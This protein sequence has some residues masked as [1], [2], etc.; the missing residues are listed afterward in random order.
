MLRSYKPT[1]VTVQVDGQPP[2]AGELAV[3]SNTRNYGGLFTLAERARVD[4]GH[5]DICVLSRASLPDLLRTAAG[6][7][8][9]G[10]SGQAGVTYMTGREV[11]IDAEESVAVQLD[12]D[13]F[14]RSPVRIGL[15]PAHVPFI[16]PRA[17]T[18]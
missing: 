14:G 8:T 9:G 17:G 18:S 11:A 1:R 2:V 4:S 7:L 13:Y 5:L 16:C 10:I 6:G 12:G 3:V 15:E